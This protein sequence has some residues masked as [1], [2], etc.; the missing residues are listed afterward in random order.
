M[1]T[2]IAAVSPQ[3]AQALHAQGVHFIDVRE[4]EE[5]AQVRIPGAQL[6]PLSELDLRFG[7]IPQD[8]PV[9]LYCR[10][11]NRSGQAVAWLMSQGWDN[12]SNLHGGI[13]AWYQ[14]GLTL[15]TAPVDAAYATTSYQQLAPDEAAAWLVRG[16]LAVDVREPQEYAL[17]HVPEAINLPLGSIAA[18]LAD[19]PR[20]REIVLVCNTGNRSSLAAQLLLR[21][22]YDGAR[23][24]NLEG[25]TSAWRT[26]G[27]P[28]EMSL[29]H[30]RP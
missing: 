19:L 7:E 27:R 12:L 21:E 11:G 16:A 15:D 18:R 5:F 20:D 13:M 17:G 23:V 8:R 9:V 3:Q 29:M 4:V 25:G 26:Q 6:I 2:T 28:V 22:G 14:H 1:I 10:S 24:A 30:L